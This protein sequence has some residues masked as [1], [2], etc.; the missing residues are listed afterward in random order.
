[1]IVEQFASTKPEIVIEKLVMCI[2]RYGGKIS[3]P[4]RTAHSLQTRLP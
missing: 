4:G 2:I 3:P 1:M